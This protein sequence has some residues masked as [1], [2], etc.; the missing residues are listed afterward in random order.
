MKKILG[1]GLVLFS[2]LVSAQEINKEAINK[3][4]VRVLDSINK[5]KLA[6]EKAKA[7]KDLWYDKI[8]LRGYAQIRYNG[9]LSTNDKVSCD[10]CDKSW[11]TT[12]TALDAKS[13][14]G[15]F[16][17]RARLVFSGQVHSNLSSIFSLILR[18]RR[19]RE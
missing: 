3:E 7:K 19:L 1:I 6:E 15:F 17:R 11:G 13:N 14:N 18:V 8:S 5:V 10:Q 16:I 9:L 4:V 12:S 2:C